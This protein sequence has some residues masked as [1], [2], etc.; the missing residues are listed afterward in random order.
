ML[1]RAKASGLVVP[2]PRY[3]IRIYGVSTAGLTPRSW[4]TMRR[5]WE[6]YFEAAGATLMS[7]STECDAQRASE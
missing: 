3:E 5:F 6:M 7:Y 1:E 2:L 4:A